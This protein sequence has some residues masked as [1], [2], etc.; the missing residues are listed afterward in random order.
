MTEAKPKRVCVSFPPAR[1]AALA[2]RAATN[3]KTVH[4]YV[5]DAVR[6]AMD[7]DIFA[8]IDAEN[9]NPWT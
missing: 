3:G 8:E 9:E 4:Q 5:I 7:R 2:N 6:E 1:Y